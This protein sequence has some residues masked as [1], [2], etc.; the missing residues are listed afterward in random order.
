MKKKTFARKPLM[1]KYTHSLPFFHS[2]SYE[3]KL[4]NILLFSL[5]RCCLY[6]SLLFSSL[7][8]PPLGST[9]GIPVPLCR[10]SFALPKPS[11]LVDGRATVII[12]ARRPCRPLIQRGATKKYRRRQPD[13]ITP[14]YA[15]S[16]T[17]RP[18]V[19]V[20]ALSFIHSPTLISSG[21][22]PSR[23]A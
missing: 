17:R 22:L 15:T 9:V 7:A 19:R 8:P 5:P 3:W 20:L 23:P 18:R 10:S 14:R 6:F 11:T 1:L 21:P 13:V 12:L 4:Y 16:L 2:F